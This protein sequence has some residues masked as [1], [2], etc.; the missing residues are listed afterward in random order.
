M[1]DARPHALTDRSQ[2]RHLQSNAHKARAQPGARYLPLW[3]KAVNIPHAHLASL[4]RPKPLAS[5][6]DVPPTGEVTAACFLQ[7]S[8]TEGKRIKDPF[9]IA[10]DSDRTVVA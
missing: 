3:R 1:T 4:D 7:S 8:A 2:S 10:Y 6:A 9:L 5:A